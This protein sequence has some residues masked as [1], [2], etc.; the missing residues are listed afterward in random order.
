MHAVSDGPSGHAADQ[1][2]DATVQLRGKRKQRQSQYQRD[3]IRQFPAVAGGRKQECQR[4]QHQNGSRE[5]RREI[6]GQ[7]IAY[8]RRD[9]TDEHE[10]AAKP[11]DES[12]PP[13]ARHMRQ[14]AE[15]FDPQGHGGQMRHQDQM[16]PLGLRCAHHRQYRDHHREQPDRTDRDGNRRLHDGGAGAERRDQDNLRRPRPDEHG[17]GQRP[18]QAEMR[19]MRERPDAEIV[20]K[21]HQRHDGR[22]DRTRTPRESAKRSIPLRGVERR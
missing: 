18:C 13:L 20:R 5:Q 7:T 2:I 22:A 14:E 17:A 6:G 1:N 10:R 19:V 9:E 4:R 15:T 16:P 21:Q 12:N 3:D 8:R 11:M